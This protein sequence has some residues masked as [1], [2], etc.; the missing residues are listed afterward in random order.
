MELARRLERTAPDLARRLVFITGG[1]YTEASRA[2]LAA[3]GRRWL[4]K[5]LDPELLR[6]LVRTA[7]PGR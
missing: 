7:G 1:A 6:E 4:E 2:F 3:N 5:P